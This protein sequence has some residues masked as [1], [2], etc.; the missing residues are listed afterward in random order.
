MAIFL[1]ILLFLVAVIVSFKNDTVKATD[2][3]RQMPP[4]PTKKPVASKTYH[5]RL[6]GT[7]DHDQ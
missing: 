6:V 3:P 4:R 7:Q 2:I 5:G 1:F